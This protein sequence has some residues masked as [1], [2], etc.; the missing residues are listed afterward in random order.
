M[1]Q[2]AAIEYCV[3][4]RETDTK[5]FEMLKSA[6]VE[7]CLSRASVSE[8]HKMFKEAQKVIMQK[9][10]AKT[11][12]TAFLDSKGIIRHEFMQENRL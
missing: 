7:E 6:Y 4:I 11:T 5:T 2:R 10:R 1:T 3:K 8:W 12:L 9:S